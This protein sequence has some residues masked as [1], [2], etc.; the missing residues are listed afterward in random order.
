[1]FCDPSGQLGKTAKYVAVSG[2]QFA[3]SV[4]KMG[5]GTETINLSFIMKSSDRKVRSS[6]KHTPTPR[7]CLLSIQP[8]IDN[9]RFNI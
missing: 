1:M 5:Q 6:G 8:I 7:I 9:D 4:L 3:A 2:D